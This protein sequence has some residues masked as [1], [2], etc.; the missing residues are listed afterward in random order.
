MFTCA[1]ES[2]GL[3]GYGVAIGVFAERHGG[4]VSV[5]PVLVG[6]YVIFAVLL[7][8][9]GRGV[10]SGRRWARTPFVLA[11]VFA[12]IVA[13][14]LL[15]GTGATPHVAGAIVGIIGVIGIASGLS[16]PVGRHLE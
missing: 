8:L 4:R 5:A 6:L 10:A 1:L 12:L 15:H 16:R 13:Y 11:Q 3:L 7:G 2:L 14:T 9:V